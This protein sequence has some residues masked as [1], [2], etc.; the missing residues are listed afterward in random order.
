MIPV[1]SA[2]DYIVVHCSGTPPSAD[3]G[4]RQIGRWH[5]K[6]G[7][8]AIGYH[9]VICRSGEAQNGR[10]IDQVGAHTQGLNDRSI[11]ICLVGGASEEFLLPSRNFTE[12]QYESL[13]VLIS[14]LAHIHPQ[15]SLVGHQDVIPGD[16]QC[17]CFDASEWTLNR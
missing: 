6:K 15:V 10:H 13:G 17:P 1:R 14:Q 4:A 12:A 5:R 3:I 11:G 8:R 9:V 2:T 16:S 7:W